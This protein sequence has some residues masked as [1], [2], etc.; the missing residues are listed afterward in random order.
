MLSNK[1]LEWMNKTGFPL[2]MKT[3]LSFR[4]QSF[5]VYQSHYYKDFESDKSREI[6]V[7]ALHIDQNSTGIVDIAYVM[8]CKASKKP[9]VVLKGDTLSD[10]YHRLNSFCIASDAGREAFADK[11]VNGELSYIRDYTEKSKYAGYD[12]RQ[13]MGGDHD[14]AYGAAIGVI[15]ACLGYIKDRTC[16]MPDRLC[17]CFPVIVVDSPLFECSLNQDGELELQEVQRSCFQFSSY[18]PERVSTTVTVITKSELDKFSSEAEM[19]AES[20]RH[21][22]AAKERELFEKLCKRT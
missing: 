1:V 12:F 16:N 11:L 6:D 22:F 8:E 14:P 5:D 17:Y 3:A 9:W 7:L 10:S 18:H 21:E 4:K 13:A 2:E 20:I 15:K 19:V